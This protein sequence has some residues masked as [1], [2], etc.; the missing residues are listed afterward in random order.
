MNY[1]SYAFYEFSSLK[2]LIT[3]LKTHYDNDFYR[4]FYNER[5]NNYKFF[6]KLSFTCV[7]VMNNFFK[8]EF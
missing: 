8:F 1:K 2:Y 4:F 6:I 7:S 5:I 3:T